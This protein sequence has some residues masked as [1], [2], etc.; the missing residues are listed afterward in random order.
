[1]Y[2]GDISQEI[3]D[4]P[5]TDNVSSQEPGAFR[6]IPETFKSFQETSYRSPKPSAGFLEL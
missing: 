3:R 1:M 2:F 6:R 5:L 4:I